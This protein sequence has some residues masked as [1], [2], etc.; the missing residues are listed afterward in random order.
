V[1]KQSKKKTEKLGHQT[2]PIIRA[3]CKISAKNN[4][5]G[6]LAKKIIQFS[7]FSALFQQ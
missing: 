7:M 1:I 6:A 3:S 2:L 5:I 4:I